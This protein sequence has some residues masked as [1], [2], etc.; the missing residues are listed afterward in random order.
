M[1]VWP[2]DK[3]GSLFTRA[4]T[5]ADAYLN[6]ID[7][8][9]SGGA[10]EDPS[11]K[12]R[13]IELF[14][15]FTAPSAD[16]EVIDVLSSG[17]LTQG[18]RVERFESELSDFLEGALYVDT[19]NSATSGL[20]LALEVLKSPHEESGWPGI[21]PSDKVLAPTLTCWAATCSILNSGLHPV[22]IDADPE[23][24]CAVNFFDLADKLTHETKV[25]EIIHWGGTPI[26]VRALD[27]MLDAA[28]PRLGFR[29]VVI[30]DCAHAFGARYPDGR[31]VGTSGNI[32]VFSFQAIKVLTCGDGGAIVFPE[33]AHGAELHRET[34][35]LRWFGI[36]R[37]RRK[38]P[39]SDGTDYRLEGDITRHGGKFHMNDYNA[40]LGLANLSHV[41]LLVDKARSN[42]LKLSEGI[43]TLT[44]VRLLM[45]RGGITEDAYEDDDDDTESLL[46]SSCWLFSVWVSNKPAF[47]KCCAEHGIVTSQVHR[48][49]DT[50]SCVVATSSSQCKLPGIDELEQHLTC[51]PCGWWV[52]SEDIARIVN[53]CKVYETITTAHARKELDNYRNND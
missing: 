44:H 15:V 11:T 30:E 18:P 41:P 27:R 22:W 36:D 14:K 42:C 47:L 37:D 29:P 1:D 25:V 13:R 19:V 6:D 16:Q 3:M 10:E 43:A 7:S 33:T 48:R 26:D 40:A 32:C 28:A 17:M 21:L 23:T 52:T 45:G 2:L 46:Y 51:L 49:N 8:V 31:I 50:H 53:A 34:R 38:D 4:I 39:A 20:Q 5:T 9:V 35:L 24:G 12:L